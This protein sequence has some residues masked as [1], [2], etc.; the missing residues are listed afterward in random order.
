[1]C[2]QFDSER[3]HKAESLVNTGLFLFLALNSNNLKNA[4]GNKNGNKMILLPNNCYCSK[5]IVNP[6]NWKRAGSSSLDKPWRITYRFY[7]TQYKNTKLWGRLISIKGMNH[8]KTIEER[9][10][11]TR[12][13]LDNE[14]YM[15]K[16]DGYNP[17]TKTFNG[18][19]LEIDSGIN[20]STPFIEALKI[21]ITKLEIAKKTREDLARSMDY[22]IESIEQLRY[23]QL[24]IGDVRRSHIRAV[25]DNQARVN[26]YSNDRYN[27]VRAYSVMVFKELMGQDAIDYNFVTGIPKRKTV[28]KIREVLTE[29]EL[30]KVKAHLKEN[31]YTFYRYMEIF[32]HSGARSS[33]LMSIKKRDVSLRSQTF[34]ITVKKGRSYAEELRAINN[35][36]LP[37]WEELLTG[38]KDADFLFSKNL[39]PGPDKIDEWQI[40]TRWRKHVKKKLGIEADFY[41]LKHLHTTKLIEAYGAQLGASVNGHKSTK[42]NEE[43][44][45]ILRKQRLLEQ[46]KNIDLEL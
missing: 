29:E 28:K 40:S 6:A 23:H 42:M 20:P 3:H 27:K 9:R 21:A 1:M 38:A 33:E 25:L 18:Q 7:D 41:S 34:K 39:E 4:K 44:Y 43:H 45:D 2:P 26:D 19:T 24:Q 13:L 5:L 11:A 36:A 14:L 46:A 10:E 31:Y 15:L 30:I 16:V 8:L 35:N 22:F 17:I 32:F 12:E 37:F